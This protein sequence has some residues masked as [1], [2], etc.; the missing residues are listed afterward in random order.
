VAGHTPAR[1][2]SWSTCPETGTVI[3]ASDAVY[4]REN[5]DQDVPP[6]NR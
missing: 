5:I 6:G 3:L 1:R 2:Q 4:V